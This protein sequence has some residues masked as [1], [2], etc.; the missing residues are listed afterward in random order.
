M[1]GAGGTVIVA[2]RR[3]GRLA[4]LRY[5]RPVAVPDVNGQRA[6]DD[7]WPPVRC[8]TTPGAAF[9]A[10]SDQDPP[11]STSPTIRTAAG[12]R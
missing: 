11:C 1:T 12:T 3:H 2:H 9:D 4:S 5:R 7:H 10:T 6:C 8:T